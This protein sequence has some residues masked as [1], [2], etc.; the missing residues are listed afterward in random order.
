MRGHIRK[1]GGPGSYEYI[2]DVGMAVAQRC[3]QA[4]GKK[5]NLLIVTDEVALQGSAQL[6]TG[7]GPAPG[8]L[9]PRQLNVPT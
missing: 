8:E 9:W 1:R 5:T 2:V 4:S 3:R 7:F 6:L